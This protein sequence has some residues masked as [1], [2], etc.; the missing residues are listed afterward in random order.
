[1]FFYLFFCRCTAK[2][3]SSESTDKSLLNKIGLTRKM[4]FSIA[5]LSK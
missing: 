3:K 5:K 1:M 2:T 4:S